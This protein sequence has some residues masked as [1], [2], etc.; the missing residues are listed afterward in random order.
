LIDQWDHSSGGGP[1]FF[2]ST[3]DKEVLC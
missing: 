2:L 1:L 3:M